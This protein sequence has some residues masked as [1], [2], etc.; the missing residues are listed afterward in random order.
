MLFSSDRRKTLTQSCTERVPKKSTSS[1][2][3]FPSVFPQKPRI[4]SLAQK[5]AVLNRY[6]R[7]EM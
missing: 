5:T 6:K 7:T 3:N 2:A 4:R 1:I